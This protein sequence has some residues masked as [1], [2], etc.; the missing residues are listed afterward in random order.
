MVPGARFAPRVPPS[1]TYH[2]P[3]DST[4]L[5]LNCWLVPAIAIIGSV[6]S[7]SD[8][9]IMFHRIMFHAK[10]S[11]LPKVEI[12]TLQCGASFKV[13]KTWVCPSEPY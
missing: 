8:P 6:E 9:S 11:Y 13:S 3:P 2:S 10:I 7:D 12:S 5:I 1:L 4:G